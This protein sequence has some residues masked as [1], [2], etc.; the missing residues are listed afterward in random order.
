MSQVTDWWV[1]SVEHWKTAVWVWKTVR[2]V[3]WSRKRGMPGS[4]DQIWWKVSAEWGG[5]KARKVLVGR[6]NWA[7]QDRQV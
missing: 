6:S 4:M 7:I 5:D 2:L 3:G 1:R